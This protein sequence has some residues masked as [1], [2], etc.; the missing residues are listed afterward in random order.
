MSA[1]CEQKEQFSG[2]H[3]ES[4]TSGSGR[5]IEILRLTYSL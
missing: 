1:K 4:L 3:A 2:T 5:R